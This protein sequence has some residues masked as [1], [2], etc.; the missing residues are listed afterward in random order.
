MLEDLLPNLII[1]LM[2]HLKNPLLSYLLNLLEKAVMEDQAATAVDQVVQEELVELAAMVQ[3][4]LEVMVAKDTNDS[5][6][7]FKLSQYL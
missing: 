6:I 3:E 7:Y 4:E 1:H 2:N 5:S